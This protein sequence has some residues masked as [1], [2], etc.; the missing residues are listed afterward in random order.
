MGAIFTTL[1]L[2][3]QKINE[4]FKNAHPRT[5]DWVVLSNIVDHEGRP[6]EEAKQK[7]V[8]LLANI[9]NEAMISTY[10][11]TVP[12]GADHFV[13]IAPPLYVDLYVLFFANFENKNYRDGLEMIS[14]TISFFQQ[15]PWFT[16]DNLP[17]LDPEIKK[18]AF[19]FS[20]LEMTDLNYLMG[21]LGA[22]YLPSVYYKVR[23]IPFQS[24][25]MKELVPGVRGVDAPGELGD[26]PAGDP[27]EQSASS[28]GRR[29][30]D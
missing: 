24:G 4:S 2:I 6:Y 21:M 23:L 28:D 19:E 17:G 16:P 3:R 1:E 7:I 5:D 20:N 18:L 12:T 14:E 11:R 29:D 9:Q 26:V 22:K 27:D 13:A 15:N 30:V 8:M 10:S 25:A